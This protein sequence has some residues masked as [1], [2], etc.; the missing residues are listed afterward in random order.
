MLTGVDALVW[1]QSR[2]PSGA[3]MTHVCGRGIRSSHGHHLFPVVLLA[4]HAAVLKPDLNLPIAELQQRGHLQSPGATQVRAEVELLLQLQ[5]LRASEGS[6]RSLAIPL[7]AAQ[8]SRHREMSSIR[9][10]T[11]FTCRAT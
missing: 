9:T 4:L 11:C 10:T 3:T 1:R 8:P 5:Q 7:E 2:E 6:A